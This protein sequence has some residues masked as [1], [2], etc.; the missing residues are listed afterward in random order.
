MRG[1]SLSLLLKSQFSRRY[2]QTLLTEREHT[3]VVFSSRQ[4]HWNH[5][6]LNAFSFELQLTDVL[7]WLGLHLRSAATHGVLS[8]ASRML[9]W[10]DTRSSDAC[11]S[12][13]WLS[14]SEEEGP[15]L[16]FQEVRCFIVEI[17]TN[18]SRVVADGGMWAWL[19]RRMLVLWL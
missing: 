8:A 14:C 6:V 10:T 16:H 7:R 5:S 19:N 17:N 4:D 2:S 1:F 12:V 9:V 15:M 18:L 13:V 11:V 3:L